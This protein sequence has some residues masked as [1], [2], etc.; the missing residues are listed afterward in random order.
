MYVSSPSPHTPHTCYISLPYTN[1]YERVAPTSP[2]RGRALPCTLPQRSSPH[3][4]HPPPHSPDA[5]PPN[6]CLGEG[7][8]H[9]S[10]ARQ[11]TPMYI[12]PEIL[13]HGHISQPAD[14]FSFGAVL[15]EMWCGTPPWRTPHPSTLTGSTGG[16]GPSPKP[17]AVQPM[18]ALL[19]DYSLPFG[20]P[21]ALRA[22]VA[23]CVSKEPKV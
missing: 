1:A 8:S 20:A 13:T 6:R 16:A 21:P 23:A 3:P 12:A 18:D 22:L 15:R 5:P 7:R 2:M 19:Y 4:H 9:I 11:G 14:I 10:N 17:P